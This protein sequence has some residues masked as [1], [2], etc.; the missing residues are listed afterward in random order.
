MD[1]IR[2]SIVDATNEEE[3]EKNPMAVFQV[4]GIGNIAEP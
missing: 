2:E 3:K 1:D 4:Y